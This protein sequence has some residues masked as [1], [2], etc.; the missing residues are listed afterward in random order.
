I[1]R[2]TNVQGTSGMSLDLRN[3]S[4]GT[5]WDDE[6][7]WPAQGNLSIDGFEYSRISKGPT[8]A[9]TRL[10]WVSRQDDFKPQPYSQ[11]A[12]VLREAGDEEGA[13]QVLFEM[14]RRKWGGD[15]RWLM[16]AWGGVLKNTV[17]YG[18][19]PEKAIWFLCGLTA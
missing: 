13:R 4:I 8:D 9:K 5:I 19:Y 7:S 15:R 12:K 1:F 18:I 10:K 16:R 11:L 2:W 6:R 14:E 3:A 17:G